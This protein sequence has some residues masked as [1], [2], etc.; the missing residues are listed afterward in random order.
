MIHTPCKSL[1]LLILAIIP[2][3]SGAQ[4]YYH[5]ILGTR[6]TNAQMQ[7]LIGAGVRG[8]SATGFDQD[9]RP[10]AGFSENQA[11]D[12]GRRLWSITRQQE[13]ST[14]WERLQFDENNRLVW[15]VDSTS[16]TINRTGYRYDEQGRVI[17]IENLASDTAMG[18]TEKEYHLW[19]YDGEGKPSHMLRVVND[20]DTTEFKLVKDEMGNLVEETAFKKG[21]AGETTYYYYNELNQ[22]TDIVR[23][24]P[25]ALRLLP[26]MMFEYDEA[27]RVIQKITVMPNPKIGYLIWRYQ[28][29]ERGL[30]VREANF[31]KEKKLIGRIDYSYMD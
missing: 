1:I 26:D 30:K 28:Y 23:Y 15:S 4:H 25:R 20:R 22:L 12:A 21:H 13:N 11:I 5:D 14:Q 18:I 19:Y 7:R 8:I 10:Q 3:A 16:T 17:Q 24:N 27:G 6:E 29:N 31:T 9:S 2:L